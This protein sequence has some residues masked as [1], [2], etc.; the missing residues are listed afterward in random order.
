MEKYDKM[1][2]LN[3]KQVV[4]GEGDGMNE[5]YGCEVTWKG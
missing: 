1:K 4:T 2:I 3:E 5:E